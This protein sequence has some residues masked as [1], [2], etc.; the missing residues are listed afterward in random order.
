MSASYTPRDM[1]VPVSSAADL[2]FMARA[3]AAGSRFR[4]HPNPRV[5]AV[6]VDAAGQ[7]VGEGGH[8]EAGTA[9]AEQIAL[10]EAGERARGGTIYVTLEP[11]AHT[12][13]TGPCADALIEAGI[14]RVVAAVVDPDERVAGKGVARLRAAGIAV[15]TGVL[16]TAAIAMDP[17]YFH[18]RRSGRPRITVKTTLT[19]D[20]AAAAA[21]GS[22]RWITSVDSRA[23]I[24]R[25]R[26]EFDALMVGSGTV[27]VDDPSLDVTGDFEPRLYVVAGRRPIP[28]SSR[29]QTAGAT[30]ITPDEDEADAGHR[31][32]VPD[33]SGDAVDLDA[34]VRHLAEDGV[35]DLLVEGGPTLVS[36]LVGA[37]LVDR[38]IAYYGAKLAAGVGR[39][40]FEGVFPRIE[41]AIDVRIV[42]VVQVGN[43]VRIEF[44]PGEH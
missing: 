17:G 16:E 8:V 12:G 27:L 40:L 18:H 6:I 44:T 38:F 25:L 14:G 29:L 9:H 36:A 24:A 7:V 20:G 22:S 30:I 23:D 43:D 37:G 28:E 11:C 31:L 5:G 41:D 21:D 2:S 3:I 10:A 26:G 19:L 35:V 42:D 1:N 39:P 15:E 13:R 32:V 34:A 4:P 33:R